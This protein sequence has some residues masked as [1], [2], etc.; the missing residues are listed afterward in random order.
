MRLLRPH[1]VALAV[2]AAGLAVLAALPSGQRRAA[3]AELR[4]ASADARS[5]RAERPAPALRALLDDVS[6]QGR[7]I[8]LGPHGARLLRR[9]QLRTKPG[10][11]VLA[12]LGTKT[13][14]GSPTVLGVAER[15]GGWIGVVSHRLRNSQVAWIPAGSAR[16]LTEPYT[17]HIDV[18]ARSI[19]VR[20]RG[21]VQRRVRIAV[22]RP[23]STTPV[24]R[25]AVTDLL[26]FKDHGAYGCCALAL[27]ARQPNIPQGWSGGDRIG[28]HGTPDEASVG[29]AVSGGCMRA[30]E[31][32]MRWMLKHV[33]PGAPV[34]VRA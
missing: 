16:L 23:G 27:T 21:R 13:I 12:T 1:V 18:S 15:R 19:V 28:I 33:R 26:R 7:L 20:H 4:A 31:A 29:A 5:P 22:G 34:H 10:G 3:E 8:P 14:W 6:P 32:D 17:M 2:V 24:G 11:R 9:T 30:K 25:F